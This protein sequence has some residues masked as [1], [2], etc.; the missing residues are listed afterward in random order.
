MYRLHTEEGPKIFPHSKKLEA[1]EPLTEKYIN[2]LLNNY[3][4]A[5][6][7]NSESL[8]KMRKGAVISLT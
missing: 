2:K 7:Q 3:W 6:R 5:I 8:P 4:L 1:T